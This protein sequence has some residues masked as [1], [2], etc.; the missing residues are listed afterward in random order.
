M[1][2]TSPYH[3][4]IF[5][6]AKLATLIALKL[7]Q[8]LLFQYK[9]SYFNFISWLRKS[10]GMAK[11]II[12]PRPSVAPCLQRFSWAM[13]GLSSEVWPRLRYISISMSGYS[14]G[15]YN[16]ASSMYNPR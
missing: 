7:T 16:L 4:V 9:H 3:Y 15:H 2:R 12:L 1:I 11:A 6:T 10:L 14:L 8:N 13:S 5:T